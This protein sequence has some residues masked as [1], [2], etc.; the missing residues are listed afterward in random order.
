MTSAVTVSIRCFRVVQLY[1]NQIFIAKVV[2]PL[3]KK[4]GFG[5]PFSWKNINGIVQKLSKPL[6]LFL[7]KHGELRIFPGQKRQKTGSILKG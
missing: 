2:V 6:T 7:I 5:S 4:D 3:S 1:F